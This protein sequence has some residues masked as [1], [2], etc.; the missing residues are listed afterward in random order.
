MGN[1]IQQEHWFMRDRHQYGDRSGPEQGQTS[2][3]KNKNVVQKKK[4]KGN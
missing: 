2:S 1:F 3:G 4:R